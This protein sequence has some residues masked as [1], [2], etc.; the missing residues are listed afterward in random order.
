MKRFLGLALVILAVLWAVPGATANAVQP[1]AIEFCETFDD[2]FVPVKP[3][4]EFTGPTISW[5]ARAAKPYGKPSIIVSIYKREGSQETLIE[6]KT[7]DVNP[8]WNT[9]GVRYMPV[10][11]EGEYTVA[12][13]TMD[14]DPLSSGTF[15][16]SSM[17]KDAPVQPEETLGARLEAMYNKYATK[18]AQEN[19]K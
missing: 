6:R 2:Q 10:P 17:K 14:G 4:T 15:L 3:G 1:G 18:K 9:S 11:E 13:T 16:I 5:I 12:L 7:F 8:T 19:G